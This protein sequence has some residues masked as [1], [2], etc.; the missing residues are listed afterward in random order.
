MRT[1]VSSYIP[2]NYMCNSNGYPPALKFT[3]EIVIGPEE[4]AR[5]VTDML[6]RTSR[7]VYME[8]EARR[9]PHVKQPPLH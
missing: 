4:L 2:L 8:S 3:F 9:M 7:D 1:L 5:P 6:C